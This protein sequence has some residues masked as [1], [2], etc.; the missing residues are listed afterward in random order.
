MSDAGVQINWGS[1]ISNMVGGMALFLYGMGRMTANLKAG[2]G[3]EY[4]SLEIYIR[5]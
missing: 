4:V 2:A 5:I 1:L 3:E